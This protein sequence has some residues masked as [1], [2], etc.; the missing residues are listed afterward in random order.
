MLGPNHVL[1]P[2]LPSATAHHAFWPPAGR[3][4][5]LRRRGDPTRRWWPLGVSLGGLA[6]LSTPAVVHL[7]WL[8]LETY[9]APLDNRPADAQAIVISTAGSFPPEGRRT[10]AE[11]NE[12]SL[13]RSS[14]AAGYSPGTLVLVSGGK[15]HDDT[16]GP[17][18]AAVMG[19]FLTK[20]GV[21]SPDLVLEEES[22]TTYENAL[23]SAEWLQARGSSVWSW[24]RMPWPWLERR[25]VFG[26]RRLKCIRP[27]ATSARRI[28]AGRCTLFS[29]AWIPRQFQ[30][31]WHEWLGLAWYGL[32]GRI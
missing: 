14:S 15:V 32:R 13:H 21:Q 29:P 30:E 2:R 20:L 3:R 7:A 11:L 9:A 31:V 22:R 23:K 24:L 27:R 19:E 4:F 18:E 25:V 12:Y 5:G 10:R 26:L 28:F 8:S 16:P 17:S 1:F 6:I